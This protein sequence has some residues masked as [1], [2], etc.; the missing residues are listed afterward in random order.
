MEAQHIAEL[1]KRHR[2]NRRQVAAA[3]GISERTM[4]RK[5]KR[6]GLA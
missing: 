2:G 1:L 6:Y 5:L 4:Y 3:L